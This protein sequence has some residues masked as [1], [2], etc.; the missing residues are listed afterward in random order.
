MLLYLKI[1]KLKRTSDII[2]LPRLITLTLIGFEVA[3]YVLTR[4]IKLIGKPSVIDV[5]Q[6]IGYN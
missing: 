2:V 1:A 5:L 4:F 6:M 3:Y